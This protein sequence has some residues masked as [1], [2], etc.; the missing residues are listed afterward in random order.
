MARSSDRFLLNI[1]SSSQKVRGTQTSDKPSSLK[2]ISQ[3][4]AFQNG[5]IEHSTK[6]SSARRLGNISGFNRCLHA[7]SNIQKPQKISSFLHSGES[8]AIHVPMLW[9]HNSPSGVHKSGVSGGSTPQNAERAFGSLSR[10]LVSSKSIKEYAN[11]RQKESAQSTCGS[12]FYDKSKEIRTAAKSVSG[13]HR[14]SFFTGQRASMSNARK[15]V[16]DQG[17]MHVSKTVSH[18]T[19]LSASSRTDRFL[20]RACSQRKTFYETNSVTSTPFLVTS[21]NGSKNNSSIQQS[22]TR[23]SPVLAKRG[24][25]FAR[26]NLLHS[27][28]L[29]SCNNRCLQ[30]RVRGALRK[31]VVSGNLVNAR[32]QNAHKLVRTKSNILDSQTFSSPAERSLCADTHRQYNLR[33]IY[34]Q[35]GRD[36]IPSTMLSSVGAMA[37]SKSQ[38]HSVESSSFSRT[39]KCPGRQIESSQDKGNGV[40]IERCCSEQTIPDVGVPL[41]RS[42]RFR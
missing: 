26:K 12:R 21:N 16:Q 1:F 19:E 13:L 29:K 33:S 18:S 36:K 5:F 23:T 39:S 9:S 2:Q 25:S 8:M 4:A 20:H 34:P 10:R 40:V 14:G 30:I 28:K 24:K 6:L 38:Q 22:Y 42:V 27:N 32:S 11:S 3:K 17:S 31:S 41:D 7:H 15:S 37:S 35:R